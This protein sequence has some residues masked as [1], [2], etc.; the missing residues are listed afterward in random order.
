MRFVE[1]AIQRVFFFVKYESFYVPKEKSVF[2]VSQDSVK[3]E[4]EEWES[5]SVGHVVA[6][7]GKLVER[8]V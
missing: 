2:L 3:K 8:Q 7:K 6:A 5:M 4:E 1:R